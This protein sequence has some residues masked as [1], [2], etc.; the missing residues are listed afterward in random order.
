MQVN[1]V[2]VLSLRNQISSVTLV[3][4]LVATLVD[5]FPIQ[6]MD[7]LIRGYCSHLHVITS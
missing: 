3:N 6:L 1:L 2:S 4:D 5:P 7:I